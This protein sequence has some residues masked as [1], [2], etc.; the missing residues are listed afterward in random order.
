[1]AFIA[2]LLPNEA[3]RSALSAAAAEHR[4]LWAESWRG[5]NALVRE[6]PVAVVVTDLHAEPRKDGALRVYRFAQRFP[7]TPLVGWGDPDGRELFRIGK[8]G[9][10]DIVLTQDASDAVLI[11]E[12]LEASLRS[13]LPRLLRERLQGRISDSALHL[14]ATAADRIPD[15]I[16]VPDMAAVLG[17]SISTLERRCEA[18]M[19]PTPGRMLLWLRVLFGLRWLLE[20]GRS[21][22]SVAAQLGYSSGAAF[23]RAIKATVGGR[24]TPLRNAAAFEQ[25]ISSFA[26]ECGVAPQEVSDGTL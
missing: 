11:A 3:D 18:L 6:R 9:A 13:A 10:R 7:L 17:Y 15:G 22:E 4:V 2:A 26:A 1:M 25:A 21:V 16:Q 24:P 5:L 19:L 14:V 23:R 12:L 20:S 8:A